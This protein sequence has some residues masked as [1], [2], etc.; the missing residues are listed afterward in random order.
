MGPNCEVVIGCDIA[1][2]L[3][4]EVTEF[5]DMENCGGGEGCDLLPTVN[6][7][8]GDMG[9]DI[10]CMCDMEPL[11]EPAADPGLEGTWRSITET[12]DSATD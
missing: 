8:G 9:C 6:C 3:N 1:P 4:C 7:G 5:G 10:A 12:T 11:P 2:R